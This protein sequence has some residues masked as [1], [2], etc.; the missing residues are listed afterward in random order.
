MFHRKE[1]T[2]CDGLSG[3]EL[4]RRDVWKLSV[5]TLS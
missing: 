1:S 5:T 2:S 3:L 4:V